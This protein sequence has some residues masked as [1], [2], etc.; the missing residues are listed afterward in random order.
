ME[1]FGLLERQ[2]LIEQKNGSKLIMA[3]AEYKE[4]MKNFFEMCNSMAES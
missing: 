4:Y 2:I 3:L 1:T